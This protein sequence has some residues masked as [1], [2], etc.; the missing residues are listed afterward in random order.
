MTKPSNLD[1]NPFLSQIIYP[2]EG[3]TSIN[4]H[5]FL[6][7]WNIEQ[8]RC[9]I[10]CVI[11]LPVEDYEILKEVLVTISTSSE[12]KEIFQIFDEAEKK[13]NLV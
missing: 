7:G 10:S 1:S 6:V 8:F 13:W 12:F 2:S 3:L 5:A 11:V 4:E 9:C